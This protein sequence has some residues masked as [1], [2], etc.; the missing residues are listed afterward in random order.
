MAARNT[1]GIYPKDKP[2]TNGRSLP[3]T[4]SCA[5]EDSFSARIKS[6]SADL[7]IWFIAGAVVIALLAFYLGY[8]LIDTQIVIIKHPSSTASRPIPLESYPYESPFASTQPAAKRM[9]GTRPAITDPASAQPPPSPAADGTAPTAGERSS[10]T[11]QDPSQP[12]TCSSLGLS[13]NFL[14]EYNY[15]AF[16]RAP[17]RPYRKMALNVGDDRCVVYLTDGIVQDIVDVGK[18]TADVDVYIKPVEFQSCMAAFRSKDA[19]AL[20]SCMAGMATIPSSAKQSM[21]ESALSQFSPA[22]R[23]IYGRFCE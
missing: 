3:I 7:N 9:I 8:K 23:M 4:P 17:L 19:M 11:S 21:C 15:Y 6:W 10:Q 1:R 12:A 13:K 22:E 16:I 5:G 18:E 20:M 14:G 2:T